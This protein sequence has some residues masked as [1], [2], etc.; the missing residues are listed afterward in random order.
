MGMDSGL[1]VLQ[2]STAV[3]TRRHNVATGSTMAIGRWLVKLAVILPTCTHSI[4]E[5]SGGCRHMDSIVRSKVM[6]SEFFFMWSYLHVVVML[7][8]TS[9]IKC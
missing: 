3:K 2:H 1:L 8:A 7:L 5:I 9:S 6:G 4:R